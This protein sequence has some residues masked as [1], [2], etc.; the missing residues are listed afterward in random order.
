MIEAIETL[1]DF[2][3]GYALALIFAGIPAKFIASYIM[4]CGG[5]HLPR[6]KKYKKRRAT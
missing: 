2:F 1:F 4:A 5:I 6:R 3:I